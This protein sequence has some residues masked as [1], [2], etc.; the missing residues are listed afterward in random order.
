MILGAAFPTDCRNL[1]RQFA[2][3]N[4]VSECVLQRIPVASADIS[5]VRTYESPWLPANCSCI[6]RAQASFHFCSLAL[7][8]TPVRVH[9]FI[10]V[11]N[12]GNKQE[13]Y[14]GFKISQRTCSEHAQ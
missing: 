12:P 4:R 2:R 1:R 10:D 14:Q 5:S 11:V 6:Y 13:R 8:E 9:F 7:H 3:G